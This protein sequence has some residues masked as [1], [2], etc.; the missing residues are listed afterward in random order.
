MIFEIDNSYKPITGRLIYRTKE[1]S[2]DFVFPTG[3]KVGDGTTLCIDTLQ[4]EIDILSH[5][6]LYP[7]GLCPHTSWKKRTLPSIDSVKAGIKISSNEE[8]TSGVTV[9]LGHRREWEVVFD[10]NSGW[11]CVIRNYDCELHQTIEIAQNVLVGLLK[12]ELVTIWLYP[13]FI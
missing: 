6:L 12:G 10:E 5:N 9:G 11:V 4:I 2:F 7:W 8:F 3:T 1:Y 13:E